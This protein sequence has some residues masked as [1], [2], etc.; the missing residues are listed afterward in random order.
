MILKY[1]NGLEDFVE[2]HYF[3]DTIKKNRI[4]YFK[5]RKIYL[6]AFYLYSLLA[7]IKVTKLYYLHT[8]IVVIFCMFTLLIDILL[9]KIVKL[10]PKFYLSRLKKTYKL[11][12]KK[13]PN[14]VKEK[15]VSLKPNKFVVTV[16]NSETEI[17]FES[18]YK[19]VE[20]NA[21]IYILNKKYKAL[22][23]IP[24][25]AFKDNDEKLDF[26]SRIKK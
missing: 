13:N 14:L 9:Y 3:L 23:I 11:G 20:N 8:K 24:Y 19:V 22:L 4:F 21:K 12:T 26:L 2:L 16:D 18:I 7:I 15:E 10:E 17:N 1:T 5:F 6:Y 25:E